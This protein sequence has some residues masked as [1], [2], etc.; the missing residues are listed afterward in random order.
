MR[1][2]LIVVGTLILAASPAGGAAQ[3]AI[4]PAPPEPGAYAPDPNQAEYEEAEAMRASGRFRVDCVGGREIMLVDGRRIGGGNPDGFGCE[5]GGEPLTTLVRARTFP[6]GDQILLVMA[7]PSG[8]ANSGSIVRLRRGAA[9]AIIAIDYMT[10]FGPLRAVDRLEVVA[11]GV[12]DIN[13]G[14]AYWVTEMR[15]DWTRGTSRDREISRDNG[16]N[17]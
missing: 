4:P 10:E 8:V 12:Q 16:C 2:A 17:R 11:G 6:D 3:Q 14:T 13:C 7:Q 1:P 5:P 15:I 9:P